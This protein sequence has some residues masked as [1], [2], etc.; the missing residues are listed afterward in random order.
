MPGCNRLIQ[1][2]A[3]RHVCSTCSGRKH[4]GCLVTAGSRCAV[5]DNSDVRVL[6]RVKLADGPGVL[7]SNC[8]TILGRLPLTLEELRREA[9]HG[10]ADLAA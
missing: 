2:G 1:A 8:T 3:N 9:G 7:C 4:R 6:E 5:C 10:S